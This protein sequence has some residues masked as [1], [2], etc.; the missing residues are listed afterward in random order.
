MFHK[1]FK[2]VFTP[3][4]LLITIDE[5]RDKSDYELLKE[6]IISNE[7]VK[8]LENGFI[9]EPLK[10]LEIKKDNGE[11]RQLGI[12]STASKLIQKILIKELEDSIQFNDKSY[13]FRKN[14]G[15]I[16][17]INRAKDFLK[18]YHFIVKVDIDNFFDTINHEKLML[19]IQKNI[20]DKQIVALIALFLKNG[21]LKE[22]HWI[23]KHQGIY[24]GDTLSPFLSN[25]YLTIFD[26]LM[27][28]EGI[29][30]VRFADDILIFAHNKQEADKNLKI[31]TKYINSLDL[32]FGQDKSYI[33]DINNGFEFLGLRFKKESITIDNDRLMNKISKISQKTKNK[34]LNNTIEFFNQYLMGIKNYYL[35]VINDNNQLTL[36]KNHMDTILIK[37]IVSAK[38]D[39]SIN[40]K[41]QFIK[42]LVTLDNFENSSLDIKKEYANL[43]IKRAYDIISF[44][45][46]LST[47]ESKIEKKKI[48][49]LKKQLKT[50]EIVLNRF[51]LYISFS[52]SKVIVKEYGK[53]I[54]STPISWVSRIIIMNKGTSISTGLIMECSNRKIDIDFIDKDKPYAQIT[55]LNTLNNELY[56]KQIDVKNSDEGLTIAISIIKS[57]MKN[58]INL[59]K[60]Y[61]RYRQNHKENDFEEINKLIIQMETIYAKTHNAKNSQSLMGFEGSLSV[62]YWRAFGLLIQNSEFKR[63]TFNAIDTINQAL[64]YGYAF[65]YHRVQSALV[66]SGLNIYNSFIHSTQ[67]HKPTLVFDVVEMFRQFVVDRE[68]ISIINHKTQLKSNKGRLTQESIKIITEHI[69]ARL[70]TP[71]KWR[72]GRYQ[73]TT[74]IEEQA[75]ELAQVVKGTKSNFKGFIGKF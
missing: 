48:E 41:S 75:V 34:N 69:Q 25:L 10:G 55:Y 5:Y 20:Q 30:F 21:M 4:N 36:L 49:Y 43:L 33:S 56:L 52:K 14:K 73:I 72:K 27:E 15:T 1:A 24:Q 37:K 19:I 18:K 70:A 13:A 64:N 57:K 7:F 9:P 50:S 66:K 44:E 59:L 26:N 67:P 6:M 42:L 45:K 35:K 65:I 2:E 46:P 54:S 17:A 3:Q 58:Q 39:K 53:V 28:K 40:Q 60:Y 74:I 8:E 29:D 16:K 31:A 61:N 63:E 22:T 23:D 11:M 12:A 68:I 32:N 71:T 62:A 47:A 38:K 51:G